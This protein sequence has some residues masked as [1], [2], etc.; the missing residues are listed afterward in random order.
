ML[1]EERKPGDEIDEICFRY[2]R[3]RLLRDLRYSR[4]APDVVMRFQEKERAIIKCF[5]KA[6]LPPLDN[7]RVLEI[8]CGSGDNLLNFISLGFQPK[9]LTGIDLLAERIR[10]ARI[11]LPGALELIQGDASEYPFE[12]S[13]YDIVFQSTVF[14]SILNDQFRQKLARQMWGSVRSG[15]GILW[16]DFMYNNPR[17]R[18]VRGISFREISRLFPYGQISRIRITLAPP[19]ARLVA[20]VSPKLYSWCNSIPLLRT[21]WLCWIQKGKDSSR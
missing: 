14:T 19:L 11:R 7:K 15:G 9:N 2:E 16:Y 4:I 6:G 5:I 1:S 12:P 13:S 8:G 20:R 10:Q 18:D 17:N 21:H 3:R